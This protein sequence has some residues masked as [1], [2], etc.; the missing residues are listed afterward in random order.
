MFQPRVVISRI[1]PDTLRRYSQTD[2]ES[3]ETL[4]GTSSGGLA[5]EESSCSAALHME[6][7]M[8][9]ADNS[10]QVLGAEWDENAETLNQQAENIILDGIDFQSIIFFWRC[11]CQFLSVPNLMPVALEESTSVQLLTEDET[12]AYDVPDMKVEEI[13][14][15]N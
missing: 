4:P 13:E 15:R 8:L 2:S 6:K 7:V 10:E 12:I 9:L 5:S 1:S 3:E 14:T 11:S